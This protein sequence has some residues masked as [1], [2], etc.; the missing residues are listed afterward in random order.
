[1]SLGHTE[2]TMSQRTWYC[3]AM[4]WLLLVTGVSRTHWV[5]YAT[6]DLVLSCN[7]NDCCWWQV[8]L[9]HTELTMSQWTW[10]CPAMKWLL[11]VTGVSRTHWVNHVTMDQVLSC[12]EM[13]VAGQW[14]VTVPFPLPYKDLLRPD[15]AWTAHLWPGAD[16]DGGMDH[17]H[18]LI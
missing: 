4:K 14:S 16:Q 3:P 2:L 10:Y 18:P 5:N 11:P 7:W 13:T 9:G 8:S 12:N 1:M 15:E 6:A 17:L